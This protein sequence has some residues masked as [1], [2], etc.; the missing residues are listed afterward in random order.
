M[1]GA[2][3]VLLK[4]A[5]ATTGRFPGG[6]AHASIVASALFGTLSRV[7][8][9]HDIFGMI[10]TQNGDTCP[11]PLKQRIKHLRPCVSIAGQIDVLEPVQWLGRVTGTR[12][13][14]ASPGRG[15]REDCPRG[16]REA[17]SG[18]WRNAHYTSPGIISGM[19]ENAPRGRVMP[20]MP[21]ALRHCK[22]NI[23][24]QSNHRMMQHCGNFTI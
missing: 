10:V 21:I 13:Q 11:L 14:R 5:F 4:F 3:E 8:K 22:G 18:A 17:A 20:R 16:E 23:L 9:Q 15:L 2:G 12:L 7:T 1:P 19:T 24:L 6:P